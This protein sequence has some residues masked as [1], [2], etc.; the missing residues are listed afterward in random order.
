M[1]ELHASCEGPFPGQRRGLCFR[2]SPSC[3]NCKIA[4]AY[5]LKGVEN[6]IKNLNL[7]KFKRLGEESLDRG[8]ICWWRCSAGIPLNGRLKEWQ[9]KFQVSV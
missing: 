3:S 6:G 5:F 9:L 8:M 7:D 4:T 1:L 2:F